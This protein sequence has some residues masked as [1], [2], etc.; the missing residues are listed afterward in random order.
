MLAFF[1]GVTA[2]AAVSAIVWVAYSFADRLIALL[3]PG[4]ARVVTRLAAFLLLCVGTRITPG[5]VED[6]LRP[7]LRPQT[8]KQGRALPGPAKGPGP[9]ETLDLRIGFQR[10][11][12]GGV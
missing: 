12:F 5:G 4:G 8:G 11:A 7:L 10:L 9:L 2:A 3:G 1:A 6:A